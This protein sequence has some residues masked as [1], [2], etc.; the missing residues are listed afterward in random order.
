MQDLLRGPKERR[1]G[2]AFLF[3]GTSHS[4]GTFPEPLPWRSPG[5]QTRQ[6]ASSAARDVRKGAHSGR[7]PPGGSAWGG[8]HG[9]EAAMG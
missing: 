5:T 8:R 6:L 4:P 1:P 3:W 9:G 2:C 7:A